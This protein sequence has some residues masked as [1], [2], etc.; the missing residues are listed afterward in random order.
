MPKYHWLPF[1]VWCISGSRCPVLFL[2]ELGAA[3]IVAS[4]IIP[5]RSNSV[6]DLPPQAVLFQQMAEVQDRRLVRHR[7]TGQ[8]Q[9]CELPHRGDL[10]EF[11]LH[12]GIAQ[13]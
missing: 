9:S 2:V 12:R 10:V 3:M 1:F 5:C 6:E 13:P 4:T 8:Q 7:A 11:F